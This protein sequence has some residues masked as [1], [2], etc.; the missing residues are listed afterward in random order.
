MLTQ[1]LVKTIEK[2]INNNWQLPSLTNYNGVSYSYG[3]VALRIK[4]LQKLFIQHQIKPGDK[5]SLIGKN[6]AEWGIIYLATITFGAVIVPLLPDFKREDVIN[7]INHSDSLLLFSGAQLKAELDI[8]KM[9]NIKAIY[10]LEDVEKFEKEVRSKETNDENKISFKNIENSE[11]AVISYTSGTTGFS[12]GVMLNHN[13]LMANVLFAQ[14]NMPL[15]PGN[16]I[17]SFLPMAH[18]YGCMF[19]F[20]FPFTL[21]CNVV[22]LTKIPSPQIIVQ[23]FKEVK[24]ELILSVPLIIEKIYKKQLSPVLSQKKMKVLLKIPGLKKIIFKKIKGKLSEVFG[25]NFRELVI[26]G[27]AFS[28]EAEHFLR[29]IGFPFTIGYG[30]TECGPLISYA[31]WAKAKLESCGKPI[32]YIE[33]K[34]DSDDPVNIPGEIL[35]KGE[36]VMLGYYKNKEATD[37]SIDVDGWL[38]SGDLGILD[39][40][41]Y[42]FIKG[43]SKSMIL[44]PSGQN[45]YPEELENKIDSQVF[46][47]ESLVVERDSKLVALVCPDP[48]YTKREK[49][50]DESL[51]SLCEEYIKTLNKDMPAYMNISRVE[52]HHEEFEKTPKKSI[53]RF[54]YTEN[55]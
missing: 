18:A 35:I 36:N 31:A 55:K 29:K 51:L 47:L 11:L 14:N 41:N 7:L 52:L 32:D 49:L 16:R 13:S 17:L 4:H 2:A 44:G 43:R 34:I 40:D 26:G 12:K 53:K 1:N 48:D 3:E 42:I 45:I 19:E 5:I 28:K 20:L 39:K 8:S 25:N 33:V 54:L 10:S 9:P 38:H 21:G 24:P 23:A 27:A 37:A 6:A 22:F 15:E 30:M 50:N 46:V